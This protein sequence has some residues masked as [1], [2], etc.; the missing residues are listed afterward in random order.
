MMGRGM[1]GPSLLR[2]IMQ[3]GIVN[4]WM[5]RVRSR[6]SRPSVALGWWQSLGDIFV[7]TPPCRVKAVQRWCFKA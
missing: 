3:N 6:V 1:S 2:N 5:A 4:L 7:E